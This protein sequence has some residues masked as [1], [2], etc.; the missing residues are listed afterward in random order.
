LSELA[1]LYVPMT[2]GE[3]RGPFGAVGSLSAL[4]ALAWCVMGWLRARGRRSGSGFASGS[5][6]WAPSKAWGPQ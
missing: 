4:W 2:A 6:T 1:A 5:P 3:L